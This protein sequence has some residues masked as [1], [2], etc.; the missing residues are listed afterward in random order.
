VFR[1]PPRPA[2]MRT[3]LRPVTSAFRLNR[4]L[5]NRSK[6]PPR[7]TFARAA[8]PL[9]P[10]STYY[11]LSSLRRVWHAGSKRPWT[12]SSRPRSPMFPAIDQHQISK[13]K[14]KSAHFS[15]FILLPGQA[16]GQTFF[17]CRNKLTSVTTQTH[18]THTHTQHHTHNNHQQ[19]KRRSRTTRSA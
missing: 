9:A 6:R 3:H 2:P 17:G 15:S 19:L 4:R 16:K 13:Q 10:I 14:Q 8:I 7:T 5:S 11:R 18:I 12:R 1:C